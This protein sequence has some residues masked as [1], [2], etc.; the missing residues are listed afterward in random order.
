MTLKRKLFRDFWANLFFRLAAGE[1]RF[2]LRKNPDDAL[3]FFALCSVEA[4]GIACWRVE[5]MPHAPGAFEFPITLR[6]ILHFHLVRICGLISSRIRAVGVSATC[7]CR[8]VN[9]S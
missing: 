7:L 6:H 4:H 2:G 9:E 1:T 8:I 5:G 3:T